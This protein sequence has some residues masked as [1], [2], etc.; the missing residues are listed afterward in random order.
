MSASMK[1]DRGP[2]FAPRI[3]PDGSEETP[4]P[5]VVNNMYLPL[6]TAGCG[7][8]T[9]FFF[10]YRQTGSLLAATTIGSVSGL[11]GFALSTMFL[12]D[13]ISLQSKAAQIMFPLGVGSAVATP[14]ILLSG[15]TRA[16]HLLATLAT[17][18][19]WAFRHDLLHYAG[20]GALLL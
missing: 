19:S 2:T 6:L 3:I 7:T 20:A 11:T 14:L 4:H 9:G 10:S 8:L 1:S 15:G 18:A 17:F 16:P 12:D 13:G 5:V